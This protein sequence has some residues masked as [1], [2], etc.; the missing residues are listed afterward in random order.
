MPNRHKHADVIIAWANG[1][2]IEFRW[3]TKHG[4]SDWLELLQYERGPLGWYED[5]EYRVKPKKKTPSQIYFDVIAQ[6]SVQEGLKAV[7]EAYK[8]GELDYA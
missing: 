3:K 1:E 2:T 6:N 4:W 5:H 8:R 7:I